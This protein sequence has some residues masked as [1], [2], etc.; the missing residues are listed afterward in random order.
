MKTSI[1]TDNDHVSCMVIST[2]FACVSALLFYRVVF[3]FVL[4]LVLLIMEEEKK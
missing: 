2:R 3:S 1:D 4:C